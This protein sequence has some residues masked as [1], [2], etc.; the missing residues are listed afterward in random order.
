MATGAKA[1]YV[2]DL[3]K[4]FVTDFVYPMVRGNAIYEGRYL[5]GEPRHWS[6][7]AAARAGA[8]AAHTQMHGYV[9]ACIQCMCICDTYTVILAPRH[10]D[11]SSP[12][13]EGAGKARLRE[14]H[15]CRPS[16]EQVD[17]AHKENCKFLA[18]GAT[19]KVKLEVR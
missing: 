17:I 14:W 2:T 13:R 11:R 7:G 6:T 3:R 15:G 16:I 19:G 5:L 12:H 9:H 4:E 18:H 8:A 1:C 10:F